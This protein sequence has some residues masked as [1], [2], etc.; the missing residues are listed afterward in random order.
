MDVRIGASEFDALVNRV[1][2]GWGEFDASGP[3]DVCIGWCEFDTAAHVASGG[4]DSK[5][6]SKAARKIAPTMRAQTRAL[7]DLL[8]ASGKLTKAAKKQRRE[9]VEREVLELLPDSPSANEF[10]ASIAQ[11][12]VRREAAFLAEHLAEPAAAGEVVQMAKF[13]PQPV[14]KEMIKR[15]KPPVVRHPDDEFEVES[16]L[17]LG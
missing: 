6:R 12:V 10:A 3:M 14:I 1:F 8:T 13:D 9:E 17:L 7:A 2:V 4:Y 11:A 15:W 5:T 16:L